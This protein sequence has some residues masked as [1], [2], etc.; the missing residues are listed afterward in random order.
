MEFTTFDNDNDAWRDN[1]AAGGG[2]GNWWKS[3][4]NNNMNGKYGSKGD[5]GHEFMFWWTNGKFRALKSMTLM[6]RRAV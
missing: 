3:C 1:C 4:G 6:F 2:G 5:N